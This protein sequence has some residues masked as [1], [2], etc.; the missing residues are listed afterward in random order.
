MEFTK[1]NKSG[2]GGARPGAGRK[3][4]PITLLKEAVNGLDDD[5]PAIF[6]KPKRLCLEEGNVKACM[7]LVD[8]RL[9]R[10]VEA[11][12]LEG[13]DMALEL[14]TES[15]DAA[16]MPDNS[17]GWATSR[18]L[19]FSSSCSINELDR[20]C[21]SHSIS[22]TYEKPV[23]SLKELPLTIPLEPL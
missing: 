8:R 15:R 13:Q 2:R 1:G 22:T 12:N 23:P 17:A 5:I 4:E 21:P 6:E 20:A 18:Y 11:I 3:K 9:R 16:R 7:Y 10:P 19:T 14:L